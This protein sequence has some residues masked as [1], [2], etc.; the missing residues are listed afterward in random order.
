MFRTLSTLTVADLKSPGEGFAVVFSAG[1]SLHR[2]NPASALVKNETKGTVIATDG[3]LG[4]CLRNGLVPEYVVSVDSDA[5]ED[6][7][8]V[9]RPGTGGSEFPRTTTSAARTLMRNSGS[10]S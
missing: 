2:C 5:T 4:Y 8:M 1:P 6:R 3:A 9:R 10:M 7:A